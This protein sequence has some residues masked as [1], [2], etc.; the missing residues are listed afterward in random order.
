MKVL[1][2]YNLKGGV[3]KTTTAV[4]LAHVAAVSGARVLL[5]DLD[6]Q[7][8]ASYCFRIKAKVKGGGEGLVEGK[9][10]VDA[11]I[12]ATDY[13][14]LDLLP[15]DFSYRN[16]DVILSETNKPLNRFSKVLKPLK[17]DYDYV[18]LDCPPGLTLSSEAVFAISDALVIPTIPTP[19]SLRT[20]EQLIRFT[21]K[22]NLPHLQLLAFFSMVDRRK[23]L[24]TQI[25]AKQ[26][27][28]QPWVLQAFIP[29][30]SAVEQISTHREPLT[31]SH[32]ASQ[33]ANHYLALW[34]EILLKV[35][36]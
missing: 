3:G 36:G 24:H 4:H 25:L 30:A 6:P 1:A 9:R 31:A 22:E 34:N 26:P 5:W 7:G 10:E 32:P 33:L 18:I 13:E 20:L 2:V 15:A 21:K 16:F 11:L 35:E 29:Y 23:K 8:A 17:D 19:L 27:T 28:M 12:R 14:G